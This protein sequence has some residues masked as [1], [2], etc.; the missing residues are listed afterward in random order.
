MAIYGTFRNPFA[1]AVDHAR[2]TI[3]VYVAEESRDI[4]P[5]TRSTYLYTCL[6]N[7]SSL[8]VRSWEIRIE[9]V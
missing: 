9:S 7:P 3:V 1:N 8:L 5:L 6:A 2:S 4:S